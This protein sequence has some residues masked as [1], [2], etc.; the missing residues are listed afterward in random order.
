MLLLKIFRKAVPPEMRE[1]TQEMLKV[2]AIIDPKYASALAMRTQLREQ[3]ARLTAS[4]IASFRK[5][6]AAGMRDLMRVGHSTHEPDVDIT[7]ADM[8]REQIP[9]ASKLYFHGTAVDP[10]SFLRP[11]PKHFATGVFGSGLYLTPQYGTALG[12][13]DRSTE[14][15]G[16]H[17]RKYTVPSSF[18]FCDLVTGNKTERQIQEKYNPLV[19]QHLDGL[20]KLYT[21][22]AQFY[23]INPQK[24]FTYSYGSTRP[25]SHDDF[26]FE[27][28]LGKLLTTFQYQTLSQND[29][30]KQFTLEDLFDSEKFNP[31]YTMSPPHPRVFARELRNLHT[32]MALNMRFDPSNAYH[33]AFIRD[34]HGNLLTKD[35]L[36]SRRRGLGRLVLSFPEEELDSHMFAA[37][38]YDGL[39]TDTTGNI[40]VF[41][42]AVHKLRFH[43]VAV[44][45]DAYR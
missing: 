7:S 15:Q 2:P 22:L 4:T 40:V 21:N 24:K 13:K 43:G 31:Y 39:K 5:I 25:P 32:M 36:E 33:D 1:R 30:Q 16:G 41:P 34:Y 6:P 10:M 9:N 45:Q 18:K 3:V 14:D 8:Q 19:K 35:A 11:D 37:M 38:G 28:H 26:D 27:H 29:H 44:P 17:I 20:K 12:Y 42:H 23:G